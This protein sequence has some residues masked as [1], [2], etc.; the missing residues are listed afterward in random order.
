MK[1]EELVKKASTL[2]QSCLLN[3]E[4]TEDKIFISFSENELGAE[5]EI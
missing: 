4:K 3:N 2:A 5:H 1:I